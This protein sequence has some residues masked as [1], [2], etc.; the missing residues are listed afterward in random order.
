MAEKEGCS[1]LLH[2]IEPRGLT[3]GWNGREKDTGPRV[4]RGP[5]TK[6]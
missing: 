1:H 3:L 2:V 6:C 4:P 5:V